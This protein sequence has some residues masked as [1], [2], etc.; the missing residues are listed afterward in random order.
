MNDDIKKAIGTFLEIFAVII[1][2]FVVVS[3]G[4]L[5]TVGI[6]RLAQLLN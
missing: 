4:I 1:M 3:C 2:G 5:A 6:A